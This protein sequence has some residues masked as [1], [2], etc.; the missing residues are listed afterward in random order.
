MLF[1]LSFFEFD[2]LTRNRIVLLEYDFLGRCAGIFFRHVEETGASG[3]QQLDL[4]TYRFRHIGSL[5]IG[6]AELRKEKR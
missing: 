1:D 5:G 6:C 2:M 4:L 3:A